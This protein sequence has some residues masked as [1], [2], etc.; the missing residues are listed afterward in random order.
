M[1]AMKTVVLGPPPAEVQALIDRRRAVGIDMFDEVWEGSYHVVPAPN[2]THA[3]LGHLLVLLLEPYAKAAGLVGTGPFNLG[4]PD[5]FRVPDQGYHRGA[6]TGTWISRAAVV[7]EIL[8]PDDETYAKLPF[9]AGH[10]VDEIL[11]VDPSARGVTVW[12]RVS[13]ERYEELG[14]S[15]LLQVSAAELSDAI[16][17]P[18]AA[19]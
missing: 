7:V 10:G 9:Y 16:A 8:S 13:D 5:D 1:R 19:Q 17:W 14:A 15:A 3:Q 6:P 11:V 4:E 12:A 18:A 2:A